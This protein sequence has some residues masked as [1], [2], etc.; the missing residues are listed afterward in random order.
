MS[1]LLLRLSGPMQAW[2]DSSRFV[3]RT[4]RR[5]PTKSG[6][7]GLLAAALGRSREESIEDIASLE[8][9]VRADQ[10]GQLLSDFQTERSLDG[11]K[12][13]PLSTRYYLA[14]AKFLVA[15][16][17]NPEHLCEIADALDSPVWPL[18]LG[19]RSCPP[20]SPI[21]IGVFDEFEDV[22]VALKK[23]PWIASSRYQ[24]AHVGD[25]LEVSVDARDG[26][27]CVSQSDFPLSYSGTGRRYANRPVYRFSVDAASLS[28]RT[29][30]D[31][32]QSGNR[33]SRSSVT[34]GD[35]FDEHDPMGFF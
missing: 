8:F 35:L 25:A 7:V 10:P 22:R 23:H 28:N 4:T 34:S 26:E 5:E 11:K 6:V 12:T 2:G 32:S 21:K 13:M 33:V 24:R 1:V 17:G 31:E 29:V 19:R 15:L 14:D 30:E 16:Q 9:G 20:D 3:M 27:P 18:F